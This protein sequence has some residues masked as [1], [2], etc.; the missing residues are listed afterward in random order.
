MLIIVSPFSAQYYNGSYIGTSFFPYQELNRTDASIELFFLS[1][2]NIIF[3]DE[4]DDDWY[5]AHVYA[6]NIS[7]TVGTSS[8]ADT[9]VHLQ[10]E[11]ASVLACAV[12]EQFCS[13]SL[14]DSNSCICISSP[15]EAWSGSDKIWKT[16]HDARFFK[17]FQKPLIYQQDVSGI[18]S[19][20]GIQ[21]LK[22]RDRLSVGLQSKIPDDQWKLEMEFW[23]A[24]T[25][26]QLQSS[27]VL[28][29]AGTSDPEMGPYL[30][31]PSNAEEK[32]V[33]R[34][35]V[36]PSKCFYDRIEAD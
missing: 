3:M 22:A 15:A 30:S 26:A 7:T 1:A 17:A 25:M 31:R 29:A 11:A 9:P 34:N 24:I 8:F 33:C 27:F 5:S 6:G 32:Q 19:S 35:Q 16:E 12:Q 14:L 2:N 4:V 21:A 13:P 10:D 23:H 20:L 36:R 28:S 18:A